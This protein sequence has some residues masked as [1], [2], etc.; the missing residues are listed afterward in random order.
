MVIYLKLLKRFH[1]YLVSFVSAVS[2]PFKRRRPSVYSSYAGPA[3]MC[4]AGCSIESRVKLTVYPLSPPTSPSHSPSQG[5][6]KMTNKCIHIKSWKLQKLL[7][8]STLATNISDQ[9]LQTLSALFFADWCRPLCLLVISPVST[10]SLKK[11]PYGPSQYRGAH[12]SGPY[13]LLERAVHDQL[14][15]FLHEM[16]LL[17]PFKCSFL[18]RVIRLNLLLSL[19]QTLFAQIWT[20][21]IW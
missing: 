21:G 7:S 16:K 10:P 8:S 4:V 14:S 12:G 11:C 18:K 19:L 2:S 13:K 20:R 6:I 9:H 1:K 3:W 15:C 17:T 5:N